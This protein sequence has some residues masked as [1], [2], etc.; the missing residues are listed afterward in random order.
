[1]PSKPPRWAIGRSALR[2]VG[3][4]RGYQAA[5]PTY[6]ASVDRSG[7]MLRR[8]QIWAQVVGI[9]GYPHLDDR[10]LGR[11]AALD[12]SHRHR[13]SL[14]N[15]LASP[16]GIF[17]PSGD[18]H[19]ELRLHHVRPPTPVLADP[20]QVALAARAGLVVE[21]GIGG[22]AREA[23][24]FAK[25]RNSEVNQTDVGCDGSVMLHVE[26]IRFPLG[27]LGVLISSFASRF[28]PFKGRNK[29]L[30]C[31]DLFKEC[32]EY[33]ADQRLAEFA[34]NPT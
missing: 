29:K 12:Q 9:L 23:F 14:D 21:G 6:S 3:Y 19:R 30:L 25:S 2:S 24:C 7:P 26:R 8:A 16:E 5:W 18:E 13:G 31:G 34:N 17:G 1:M 27:W 10:G 15:V 4:R 11:Q 28:A 22:I 32:S 20:V 33:F